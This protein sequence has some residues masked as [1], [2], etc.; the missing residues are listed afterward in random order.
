VGVP[1][2]WIPGPRPKIRDPGYERKP[3]GGL[4]SRQRRSGLKSGFPGSIASA[5]R[6]W[7]MGL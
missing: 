7:D 1:R 5:C 3:G 2:C 6:I 4:G